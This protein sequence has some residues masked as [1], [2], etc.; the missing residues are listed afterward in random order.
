MHTLAGYRCVFYTNVAV[1]AIINACS[2]DQ[3]RSWHVKFG[4]LNFYNEETCI[5]L[6]YL[7]EFLNLFTFFIY[8]TQTTEV[9]K[10]THRRKRTTKNWET[11]LKFRLHVTLVSATVSEAFKAFVTS[12]R[13]SH[14]IGIVQFA[15]FPQYRCSDF[16]IGHAVSQ[17]SFVPIDNILFFQQTKT[18][19]DLYQFANCLSSNLFSYDNE[20]VARRDIIL[21][22]EA[23]QTTYKVYY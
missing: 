10:T 11:T 12:G 21:S 2:W 18:K 16:R 14:I 4:N 15:H 3:G 17:V 7:F 20:S 22:T 13:A 6:P 19:V 23:M 5:G 9:H 1:A 8:L